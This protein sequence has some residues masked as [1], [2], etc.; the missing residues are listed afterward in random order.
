MLKRALYPDPPP[1]P[2]SKSIFDTKTSA[3]NIVASA[4]GGQDDIKQIRDD[5][6]WLSGERKLDEITSLRIVVLERQ[7]RPAVQLQESSL[8]D[9]LPK[10]GGS[11]KGSRFQPALSASRSVLLAKSSAN[12]DSAANDSNQVDVRRNRLF[13]IY[14][15]ERQY[16]IKTCRLLVFSALLRARD[17]DTTASGGLSTTPDWVGKVG[18]D[19]LSAW[20]ISG[21]SEIS[22]RN[23]FVD[24]IDAIQLRIRGLESGCGWFPDEGP[25]EPIQVAWC[26][27]HVIDLVTILEI[28]LA[29][30]GSLAQL[31]RS[32][33]VLSWFNLM[34]DYGFF[35]AFEPVSDAIVHCTG[36]LTSVSHCENFTIPTK[37]RFSLSYLSSLSRA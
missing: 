24:G 3:I 33:A 4:Q 9:D 35:E 11:L 25:Q 14:L 26:E 37:C 17:G 1:S 28:I 8:T 31:S 6:L 27:S 10:A 34:S 23:I 30:F 5:A 22:G 2:E 18:N 12:G 19:I 29:L 16:R 15:A 36:L 13:S 32:D 7:T 21:E 20:D